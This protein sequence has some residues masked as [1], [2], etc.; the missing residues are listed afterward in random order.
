M[1]STEQLVE[2]AK[3]GQ[4]EAIAV[5]VERYERAAV[6]AAWGILGDFHLAQDVTQD[7]FVTAFRQLSQ[8]RSGKTFGSWLM[9]SVRRNAVRM[10]GR[11]RE[12]TV[13]LP[14]AE[15]VMQPE[16]WMVAFQETLPML[17][18]LPPQ[19][20]EVVGLR[21]LNG[22]SVSQIAEETGRP[23]GTVTKQLSRAIAR[24]REMVVGLEQ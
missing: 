18:E 3:G 21:Y 13:D 15:T 9:T 14:L 11:Q 8:L 16:G 23:I 12:T 24:L 1:Q 5:L 10:K 2:L 7:S 22:L 17:V 19:E 6:A 20:Y 4:R